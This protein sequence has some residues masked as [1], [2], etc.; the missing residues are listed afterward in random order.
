[1]EIVERSIV[2]SFDELRILLYSQGCR[3][4]EGVYMPEKEFSQIDILRALGKLVECGLLTPDKAGPQTESLPLVFEDEDT[5]RNDA[6]EDPGERFYIRKDL[7]D[8]IRV[9]CDH[10]DSEII[11]GDEGRRLFCYYAQGEVVTSERYPG[12]PDSVRLTYY[13]AEVFRERRY[14][15]G[16]IE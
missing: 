1:M 16:V 9:I 6:G 15:G 5:E 2:L 12:R 3:R 13:P 14:K 11:N 8:M 4:C 7:L 10:R